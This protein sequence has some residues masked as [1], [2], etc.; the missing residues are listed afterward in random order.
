MAVAMNVAD[1]LL[2]DPKRINVNVTDIGSNYWGN[3]SQRDMHSCL[4]TAPLRRKEQI[5][6]P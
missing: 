4:H 5:E 3:P 6:L 1:A 2:I